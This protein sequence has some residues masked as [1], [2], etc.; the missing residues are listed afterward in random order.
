[1]QSKLCGRLT[2]GATAPNETQPEQADLGSIPHTRTNAFAAASG[3]Q[4][5]RNL[6][7]KMRSYGLLPEDYFRRAVLPL[8]LPGRLTRRDRARTETRSTPASTMIRPIPTTMPLWPTPTSSRCRFDTRSVTSSARGRDLS[9]SASPRSALELAR[10]RPRAA[11]RLD[12]RARAPV[13]PQHRRRACR[14][15]RIRPRARRPWRRSTFPWVYSNRA[16]GRS[17]ASGWGWCGSYHRQDRFQ[18]R[19]RSSSRATTPSRSSPPRCSGFTGR[20]AGRRLGSRTRQSAADYSLPDHARDRLARS[21]HMGRPKHRT[22]C[23]GA[24]RATSEVRMSRPATTTPELPCSPGAS[25]AARTRWCAGRSRRRASTRHGVAGHRRRARPS[26]GRGHLHRRLP[27]GQ[28]RRVPA[29]SYMPVPLDWRAA[30]APAWHATEQA[31]EVGG[32]GDVR[33]PY[34]I[35]AA[36]PQGW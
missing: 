15:R 14:D 25:A 16:H 35:A 36:I 31:V 10:V 28:R 1:M 11:R 23:V 18:S 33:S 30:D 21:G 5:A 8:H 32:S 20:S 13:R 3:Y 7:D 34:V 17:V 2:S 26:A 9:R 22:S 6:F 24:N 4:H 29:G 27:P 12:R 19:A